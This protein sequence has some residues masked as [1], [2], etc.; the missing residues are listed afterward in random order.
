MSIIRNLGYVKVK[1]RKNPVY[2]HSQRDRRELLAWS[3][4]FFS[5]FFALLAVLIKGSVR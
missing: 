1:P 3:V 5:L 2:L 4:F